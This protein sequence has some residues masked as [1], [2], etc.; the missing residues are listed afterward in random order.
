MASYFLP[1]AIANCINIALTQ[2]VHD[3][4]DRIEDTLKILPVGKRL[5]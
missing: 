1:K 4:C 3:N 5:V 2:E